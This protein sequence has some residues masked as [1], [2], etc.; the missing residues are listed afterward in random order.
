MRNRQKSWRTP[1]SSES[2]WSEYSEILVKI[3]ST[4]NLWAGRWVE[5]FTIDEHEVK[6]R[7]PNDRGEPAWFKRSDIE[8]IA[9]DLND[10]PS[11]RASSSNIVRE[12][13]MEHWISGD[14]QKV[15]ID[16]SKRG[17]QWLKQKQS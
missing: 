17:M 8:M 11:L 1:S 14:R 2:G 5:V 10:F 7:A 4:A 3:K 16:V 9:F 12:G 13:E 6:V 15:E